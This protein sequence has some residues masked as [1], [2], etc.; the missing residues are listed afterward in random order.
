MIKI[1]INTKT[2]RLC[3]VIDGLNAQISMRRVTF[4]PMKAVQRRMEPKRF[5][6]PI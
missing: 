2:K 4:I 1:S 6:F 5:D 3:E